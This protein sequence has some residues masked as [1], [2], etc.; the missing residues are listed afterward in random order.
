[1]V[2]P[3]WVFFACYLAA[4]GTS[5]TLSAASLSPKHAPLYRNEFEIDCKS[6]KRWFQAQIVGV[7]ASRGPELQ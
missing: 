1:M 6:S 3:G 7:G 2:S 5:E 4:F